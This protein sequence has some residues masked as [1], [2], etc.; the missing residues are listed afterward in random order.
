MSAKCCRD[1]S[2]SVLSVVQPKAQPQSD[3]ILSY[4]RISFP[5]T[6]GISRAM[7]ADDLLDQ[8]LAEPSGQWARAQ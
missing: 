4:H 7:P 8:F 1:S 2:Y 5:S 3:N 6:P